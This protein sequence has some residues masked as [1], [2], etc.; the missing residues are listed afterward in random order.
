L[1][2][3]LEKPDRGSA[4]D[5]ARLPAVP[6]ANKAAAMKTETKNDVDILPYKRL[7]TNIDKVI[8]NVD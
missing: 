7:S 1:L 4:A 2:A 5:I 8:G 6:A 3:V